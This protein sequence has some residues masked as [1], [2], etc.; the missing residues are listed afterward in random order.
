LTDCGKGQCKTAEVSREV[1]PGA[2]ARAQGDQTSRFR[3]VLLLF[4]TADGLAAVGLA[5]MSAQTVVAVL[6]KQVGFANIVIGI[7]MAIPTLAVAVAQVPCAFWASRAEH[8]GLWLARLRLGESL[9]RFLLIGGALLAAPGRPAATVAL[10]FLPLFLGWLAGGAW[11]PLRAEL[12]GRLV[13][14]ALRGRYQATMMVAKVVLA[15]AGAALARSLLGD[16][17]GRE[18][19]AACFAAAA[20]FGAVS[21]LPMRHLPEPEGRDSPKE[22]AFWAY[23]RAL[24]RGMA[25]DANCRNFLLGRALVGLGHMADGFLAVYALERFHLPVSNAPLFM[26]PALLGQGVGSVLWGYVGDRRGHRAVQLA[27]CSQYALALLVALVAPTPWFFALTFCLTGMAFAADVV[28]TTNFLLESAPQS[29]LMGYVGLA[30]SL[31]SPIFALSAVLGGAIA[32]LTSFGVLFAVT[33][34]VWVAALW[35]ILAYVRD[36]RALKAPAP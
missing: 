22:G 32:D 24:C 23:L 17:G 33:A 8:K 30:N 18:G 28:S 7:S 19:F 31:I 9:P 34:L 4:L 11:R 25:G 15:L 16:I 6:L 35:I 21:A 5:A 26:I 29:D 10:V 13:S 14:Q 27:V 36:P 20:V 1:E 2:S 3:R 12:D